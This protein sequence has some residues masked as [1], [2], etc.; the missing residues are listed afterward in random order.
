MP[1]RLGL[2]AA[3]DYSGRGRRD[4]QCAMGEDHAR[5]FGE[6]ADL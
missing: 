3:G 4:K 6:A 2:A 5:Y 1:G